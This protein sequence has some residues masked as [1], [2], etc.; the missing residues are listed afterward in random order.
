MFPSTCCIFNFA[1]HYNSPIYKKLDVELFCDFYLGDK[2]PYSINRMDYKSLKGFKYELKNIFLL[3]NFYWQKG[4]LRTLFKPY[5]NYIFTGEAFC[6]STWLILFLALFTSKKTYL[7]THGWYGNETF[8]KRVVKKLFFKLANHVLLYGE[9]AKK[10]MLKEGFDEQVLHVIYNSLDIEEQ[11]SFRVKLTVN[12]IYKDHFNN[13]NPVLIYIGRIQKVK[14][15]DY[16]IE[17]LNNLK[18]KGKSYNFIII[19]EDVEETDL[20]LKINEYGL[21]SQVWQFGAC[22]DERLLSDLIYNADLCVSPGN[23]GLTAMHTLIYGTPVITHNNFANQMPEFEVIIPGKTGDYF[24]EDS[25]NDLELKI[26]NWIEN[27]SK[28]REDIRNNCYQ[29]I[30]KNYN[31]ISQVNKLK[32][33]LT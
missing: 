2:L 1:P 29:V 25:I 30:S 28:F 20:K 18:L 13:N 4:A 32:N 9:Y 26:I 27:H 3:G 21:E 12:N 10:L 5:K 24:I 14:K 19:G 8:I 16:V 31:P 17:V 6:L 11:I 7:W 22:Y 23:V 33:I 15:V